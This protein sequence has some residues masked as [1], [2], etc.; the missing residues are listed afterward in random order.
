MQRIL[1][2]RQ[3]HL[4]RICLLFG[5]KERR[6]VNSC[7]A[8]NV[9]LPDKLPGAL[10]TGHATGQRMLRVKITAKQKVAI[11]CEKL[12]GNLPGPCRRPIAEALQVSLKQNTKI[13]K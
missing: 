5:R 6:G 3:M 12:L 8:V 1:G 4:Q 9:R 7:Q 2:H 11:L 10:E 13:D